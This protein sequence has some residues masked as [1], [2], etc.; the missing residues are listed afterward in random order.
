MPT[1][2]PGETPPSERCARIVS[3]EAPAPSPEAAVRSQGRKSSGVARRQAAR[4]TRQSPSPSSARSKSK[5]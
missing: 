4:V 3:V 5:R 1:S 2:P